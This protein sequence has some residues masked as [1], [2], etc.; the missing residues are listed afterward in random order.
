[1]NEKQF[2]KVG[3]LF[4]V[5]GNLT[6]KQEHEDLFISSQHMTWVFSLITDNEINQFGWCAD[7][8]TALLPECD[9]LVEIIAGITLKELN[10]MEGWLR[11][12]NPS[13]KSKFRNAKKSL[14]SVCS[15]VNEQIEE[16]ITEFINEVLIIRE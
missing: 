14:N 1:M 3:L 7:E 11:V 9:D 8:L 10:S 12:D 16:Q 15:V 2:I 4:D 5:I 13:I 6:T